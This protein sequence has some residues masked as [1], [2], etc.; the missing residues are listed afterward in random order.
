MVLNKKLGAGLALGLLLGGASLAWA[1]FIPE[2]EPVWEEGQRGAKAGGGA[3]MP[4]NTY[5]EPVTGME[6]VFVPGG[7]FQMGDTFG[8][9]DSDEKPVHEVCVD[10]FY[11]GKY[12]VTQGQW[13]KVMGNNPSYFK[14]GDNYPV[15]TVS[16]NDAQEFISKL[17]AGGGKEFRLSTEAEWE[18]AARS[19]GKK[20]KYAGGND[21]DAV[22]WYGKNSGSKTQPVGSKAAN[23]LGIYDMSGNVW[24]WCRDWYDGSYYKNSPRQ[25]PQG[26]SNGADRVGRGGC[27]DYDPGIVRA[28]H[29]AGSEPASRYYILGFRLVL[30]VQQAR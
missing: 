11:M 27:W 14:N 19:G 20:E 13:R 29:R 22:A 21:V 1:G 23:G 30:P 6:F 8:D 3:G 5:T 17:N 4:D 12:E 2:F 9:G 10:G 25:K 7:C 24:E 15:E 16:W 28:A 26:P 18:Y